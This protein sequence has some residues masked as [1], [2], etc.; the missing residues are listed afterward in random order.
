MPNQPLP[1][2][3]LLAALLVV[4][5]AA[6]AGPTGQTH[7]SAQPAGEQWQF[8]YRWV[9]PA[10]AHALG[11]RLAADAIA[12]ARQA[13]RAYRRVDLERAAEE[14]LNRQMTRALVDLQRAYPGVELTLRPDR[15]IAWQV[16]PAADLAAR[17]HTLFKEQLDREIAAIQADY[18]RARISRGADDYFDLKAGSKQDLTAIQ[19]RLEAA[20]TAANQAVARY[21]EQAQAQVERRA[22]RLDGELRNEFAAIDRR[23][24]DFKLAYF[25]ERLYRL[26]ASGELYPDYARIGEQA[27]PG[28][29]PVAQALGIQ[30]QGL[31]LRAAVTQ[32]LAFIQTIP[33][34]PLEDRAN[35]AGFLP[36]L[37]MLADNRGDCDTK[38]VAFAALVHLL[39]PKVPSALILVPRHA[40]L[41]LGLDPAPGDRLIRYQGR[42]WV[43]AEPVGPSTPPV[44]QIGEESRAA[45]DKVTAAVPLFR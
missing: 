41:A 39:F 45:L 7:F 5:G 8:D 19:Q 38:S 15:S 44:G 33:Y 17:Q 32:A 27:L 10:G 31:P 2:V 3:V 9:D 1:S 40:L 43:L 37:A 36:P 23:M 13:F 28:L 25:R 18:P 16:N 22:G 6:P 29:A 30:L 24:E 35:D 34:D 42:D 21:V 11:F 14:E 12:A 20:Q 4:T 26:D